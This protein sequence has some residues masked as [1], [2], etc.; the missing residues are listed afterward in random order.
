MLN[1]VFCFSQNPGMV[2]NLLEK[3]V[4]ITLDGSI[5]FLYKL[6]K[7][8]LLSRCLDDSP[9]MQLLYEYFFYIC[10]CVRCINLYKL[11]FLFFLNSQ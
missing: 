5:C 8:Y 3:S 4:K 6:C 2:Q 10:S 11:T 9:R 1:I 7:E